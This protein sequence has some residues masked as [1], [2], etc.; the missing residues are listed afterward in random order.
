M[1]VS[2]CVPFTG[3]A[4][5]DRNWRFLEA[6]YRRLYPEWE[7]VVEGCEGSWCK[8]AAIND[9]VSRSSGDVLIIADADVMVAPMMLLFAL[10]A[11][12]ER[13]WVIPAQQVWRMNEETTMRLLVGGM[14]DTPHP[15]GSGE[16]A[17]VPLPL[18]PG[19]GMFVV[20]REDWV[21]MDERFVE[22]G[23][24]DISHG[25]ALETLLG[26]FKQLPGILWH[27]WHE[28]MEM[29]EG[30][31]CTLQ[32]CEDLANRYYAALGNPDEMR[33]LLH[34]PSLAA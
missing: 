20:K 21:P 33:A 10:D 11:L 9:A 12:R 14:D 26:P 31:R 3:E 8:G 25:R 32:E 17:R 15:L 34:E 22:W 7:I 18:T 4:E 23:G 27:L 30:R 29:R 19:G 6:R 24:E 13:P 5:R 1:S 28:P 2:I 16:V